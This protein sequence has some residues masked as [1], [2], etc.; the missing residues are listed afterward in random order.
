MAREPAA[1]TIA[2]A[3]AAELL[4]ID[5]R[6][7]QRLAKEGFYPPSVRGRYQTVLLVRGYIRSLKESR[8]EDTRISAENRVRDARARDFEVRTARAARELAPIAEL[9]AVL[10]EVVGELRAELIGLGSEI[11]R[12]LDLRRKIDSAV[13]AKFTRA[14]QAI[15]K[16]ASALAAHGEALE[17]DTEAEPG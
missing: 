12:D 6:Q 5:K 3:D 11:T 15:V 7:V 4:M 17:A 8:K 14:C 13:D 1:G 10:D 16:K 2:A 9:E